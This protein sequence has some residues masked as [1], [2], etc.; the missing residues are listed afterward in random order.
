MSRIADYTV[1]YY[2]VT[3]DV[4]FENPIP[5]RALRQRATTPKTAANMAG[6]GRIYWED[7]TGYSDKDVR[8][9]AKKM[10]IGKLLST[11]A[12][13]KK[14][15]PTG[16]LGVI[17]GL[18]LAPHFYAN[19]LDLTPLKR[20]GALDYVPRERFNSFD[21]STKLTAARDAER[22]QSELLNFCVGASKYCRQTCL[23]I[24]GQNPSTKEAAHAKMKFTNALLEEPALFVALLYKQLLAR[25]RSARAKG[26]DLICR[27]NMLSDLPWYSMCPELLE[28][29]EG[30]V[31]F[32][33][34][35][36]VKYWNRADYQRVS[37]L[38]DLTFS[39]SGTN[40]TLCEEALN[41]GERIAVCFAPA[42]PERK[43]TIAGRTTWE[44]LNA[45][46]LVKRGKID[47]F[48]GR[49]PLVDGDKSDY[50]IDDPQPSIVSLNFKRPT[51]GKGAATPE[52]VERLFEEY[53][54]ESRRYFAKPVPDPEG[55]GA[56]Y[57]KARARKQF[58]RNLGIDPTELPFE[59]VIRISEED[60]AERDERRQSRRRRNPTP[61]V[62]FKPEDPS[63]PMNAMTHMPMAPVEGTDLLIG[64]HVPTVLND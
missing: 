44:E 36:K 5:D 1:D 16:N 2:P 33:D 3:G 14:P 43:A 17:V 22:P 21:G 11:N 62:E 58:W 49:W 28:A 7:V 52:A 27:L 8:D 38:L 31:V 24:T 34:Y 35:T 41:A 59:E 64:P 63:E 25:A 50:R 45:S 23:V 30:E 42:D 60:Q 20:S 18:S 29:L 47:L 51:V 57:S 39:F 9:F 32:Y 15:R 46:P 56:R 10:E 19:I 48:G 55:M 54:P 53:V 12:K 40:D 13:T 26:L 61:Q 4:V 37:H 6:I